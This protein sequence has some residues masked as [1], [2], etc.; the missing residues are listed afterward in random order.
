MSI[1]NIKDETVEQIC[2]NCGATREIALCDLSLG[3]TEEEHVTPN[4]IRLPLCEQCPTV[5]Y[6]VVSEDVLTQDESEETEQQA[7]VPASAS[8]TTKSETSGEAGKSSH[9]VLVD[10]LGRILCSLGR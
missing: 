8:A 9:R 6:L 3:V 2:D 1:K 4:V 7:T 5:E 10:Q